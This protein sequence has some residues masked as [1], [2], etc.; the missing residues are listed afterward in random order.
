MNS[1][2]ACFLLLAP[3]R[4]FP[5]PTGSAG[6]KFRR[7]SMCFSLSG[8]FTFVSDDDSACNVFF[9]AGDTPP[10]NPIIL[11]R[12]LMGLS[13]PSI[14]RVGLKR[15]KPMYASPIPFRQLSLAISV[16]WF[17]L[18]QGIIFSFAD[19]TDTPVSQEQTL[20]SGPVHEAFA[21]A[22]SYQPT[23][24]SV[25]PKKP[26]ENIREIPPSVKPEGDH[27]VW[28]PG[29]WAW[30]VDRH[31]FIWVS[32]IWRATPPGRQWVSGEWV[33][34]VGGYQWVSGYWADAA[35]STATVYLPDPPATLEDGPDLPAP[36][37]DYVWV[38]GCWVWTQGRYDWSP[39]YWMLGEADWDWCPSYYSWTP[40]GYVFVGGY[41]D[42]AF[43]RRGVLFAPVYFEHHDH[44]WRHYRYRPHDEI[45][46]AVL[47]NHLFLRSDDDHYYFGDYYSDASLHRGFYASF[48]F[49]S[50]GLGY[51]PVFVHERWEHRRDEGWENHFEERYHSG[52]NHRDSRS[53]GIWTSPHHGGE[54]VNLEKMR[55]LSISSGSPPHRRDIQRGVQRNA[56]QEK[57]DF[58][59][60]N[61]VD[62]QFHGWQRR[63]ETNSEIPPR[64]INPGRRPIPQ[65]QRPP[66]PHENFRPPNHNGWQRTTPTSNTTR[67]FQPRFNYR[68]WS[69]PANNRGKREKHA[70]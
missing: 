66:R 29:Y 28:I 6:K 61:H 34:V 32:G 30:D 70:R 42:Y 25:V 63:G 44:G 45:D 14:F 10:R 47:P 54:R 40:N 65:A 51:D 35:D 19:S 33:K 9:P 5:C 17:C 37:D 59:R 24:G 58:A 36:S 50:R 15:S 39:G 55:P 27:V 49:E 68:G 31:D 26:P 62:Q 11:K 7:W 1:K 38:P 23:P 46:L 56:V 41:W 43:D 16:F 53:T 2:L 8:A 12:K 57:Q 67:K 60:P 3:N 4:R 18:G 20:T 48:D 52:W 69:R 21:E 64:S 22:E 13:V